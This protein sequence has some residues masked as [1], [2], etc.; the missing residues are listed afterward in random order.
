MASNRP[1]LLLLDYDVE[2]AVAQVSKCVADDPLIHIYDDSPANGP[3]WRVIYKTLTFGLEVVNAPIEVAAY[4]RVFCLD[5][6]SSANSMLSIGLDANLSGGEKTAP[7]AA[8]LLEIGAYLCQYL[9]PAMIAW[10]PGKIVTDPAYFSEAVTDYVNGGAFPALAV[11]RFV[12]SPDD[13][14]VRTEGLVWFSGQELEL[15]GNGLTKA[16]L[17]RRAVRLIHDIAVNGPIS[18]AEIVPDVTADASLVL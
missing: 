1:L 12:F 10:V 13:A 8:A 9:T 4:D 6:P 18:G 7:I 3:S 2:T 14:A 16:D 15:I 5:G 11:V 17:A